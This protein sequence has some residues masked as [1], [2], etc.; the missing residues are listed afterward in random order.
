MFSCVALFGVMTIV[1]G[2]SR[3][4][5]LSLAALAGLGAADM[6]SVVIRQ[7]LVQINTP[8][9][10]RGRVSAVSSIF[11]GA[12]N[13]LGEF[14]SGVTAAALGAV[15]AAVLGGAGTLVVVLIWV[16]LFPAVRQVD[17]LDAARAR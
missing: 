4:F 13:Q 3:S 1:F 2:L 17:R 15:P 10:N 6:V 11:I 12:S 5:P 14:E 16:F 8:D 9:E 7:T